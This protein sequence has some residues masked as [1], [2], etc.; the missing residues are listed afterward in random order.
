MPAKY[1]AF[2]WISWSNAWKR[3]FRAI[4][5]T[6]PAL[7]QPFWAPASTLEFAVQKLFEEYEAAT[8]DETKNFSRNQLRVWRGGRMRVVRELVDVVGD[9]TVTELTQDDGIDYSEWWR[10]RI[11]AGETNAQVRK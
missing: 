5:Q 3:C 7:A 2:L 9:K 11:V 6:T 1:L 10:E 4:S 8:R